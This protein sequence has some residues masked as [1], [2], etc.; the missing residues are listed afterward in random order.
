MNKPE[1]F[2]GLSMLMISLLSE[3]DLPFAPATPV[4]VIPGGSR[5]TIEVCPICTAWSVTLPDTQS[6]P[7]IHSRE[8]CD[9]WLFENC[10]PCRRGFR[11]G[12]GFQ[13]Q[14]FRR[15]HRCLQHHVMW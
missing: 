13:A 5:H 10:C 2:T 15:V 9:P 12:F 11:V 7:G 1:L 14:S 8:R 6:R 4:L 3:H